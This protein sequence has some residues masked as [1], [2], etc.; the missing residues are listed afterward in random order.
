M[1]GTHKRCTEGA[2]AHGHGHGTKTKARVSS[3]RVVG[4]SQVPRVERT[5]TRSRIPR[6][7]ARVVKIRGKFALAARMEYVQ[8][9][10]GTSRV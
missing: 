4:N 3:K 9:S 6:K 2:P 7:R 10:R 1:S 5:D 8:I